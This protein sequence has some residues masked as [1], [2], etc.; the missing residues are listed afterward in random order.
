MRLHV[1]SAALIAALVLGGC[2]TAAEAPPAPAAPA[3][4]AQLWADLSILAADDMQGRAPSTPG[5]EAARAYI[6]SRFE[7]M[8]VA[9]P[10]M[11]RLQPFQATTRRGATVQ[12]VNVLGMIPG[13]R[14]GDRYIVVTAHY[15]HVGAPDGV[16]HNGADDNASGVATLLALAAELKRQAPEHSVIFVAFDAEENGL[17]GAKHFVEAPPVPLE[18]IELNLNFDM[19]ARA[20]TD[21]KLWVTGTYQ[22]PSFRPLLEGIA[23]VGGISLAF[24][25]DTPQDTGA[26]NWVEASDHG[27][28]FRANVPFLYLGVDFHP[29]Y[30]KPTDDVERVQP[31]VFQSS[32]TLAI[33]SFRALDAGLSR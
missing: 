28:F 22:H 21:G 25:K 16:I 19:T 31:A 32:T 20:E 26:N 30:H 23:P 29:D 15:D 8:G 5:G 13:T 14:R 12:G 24:G 3:V 33:Q 10:A 4:D 7:E 9:A 11:G 2:M 18:S 1:S 17:L 6:V 27:A